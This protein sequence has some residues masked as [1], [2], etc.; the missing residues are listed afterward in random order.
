MT[1][2][3]SCGGCSACC[4]I[5]GVPSLRKPP[6]R[7]CEHQCVTGCANY[8]NRPD[9]CREF[10]CGWSVGHLGEDD[11]PDK[12]G[13]IFTLTKPDESGPWL[14]VFE[15]VPGAYDQP[16]ARRAIQQ[17]AIP[18]KIAGVEIMLHGQIGI[19]VDANN[20]DTLE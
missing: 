10:E 7:R 4:E 13:L 2:G 14:H 17:M 15:V 5:L 6:W 16:R 3:R 8:S 11:R 9:E 18:D 12:L 20:L 19:V 1:A